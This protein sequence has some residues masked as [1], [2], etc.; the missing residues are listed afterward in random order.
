MDERISALAPARGLS[1][2]RLQAA[3]GELMV[4]I[5][6]LET[7]LDHKQQLIDTLQRAQADK[8]AEKSRAK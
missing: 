6:T 1:Q 2:Q 4:R 8:P 3:L 7:E 5:L